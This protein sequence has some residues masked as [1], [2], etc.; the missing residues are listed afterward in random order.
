MRTRTTFEVGVFQLGGQAV[1]LPPETIKPGE[2]EPLADIARNLERWVHAIVARVRSHS[3]LVELAQWS[4]VP[5]INALSDREHPCQVLADMQTV[6][7]H[8]GHLKGATLLFCGDGNNV[9]HSL[10]L[11]CARL[12]VNICVATPPSYKPLPEIIQLA[13]EDGA[14]HGSRVI[15]GEKE[16][17]IGEAD[18]VYTDVWASMGQ[19]DQVDRRRKIFGDGFQVNAEL[20]SKAKDSVIVMHDLPAHRGEE[21]TDEVI[22]GPRSVV[23]DQAENRLHAQKALIS[24]LVGD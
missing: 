18:V 5:V 24:L 2:R 8:L 9:C 16:D 15:W 7:E 1:I 23:F 20:L 21:I 22:E 13:E 11:V 4:R 10:L 12:G 3:T 17:F 14:R 19:E 6:K